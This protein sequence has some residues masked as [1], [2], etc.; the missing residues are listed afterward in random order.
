V[1]F[2]VLLMMALFS[3][4]TD[5]KEKSGDVTLFFVICAINLCVKDSR[6][7]CVAFVVCVKVVAICVVRCVRIFCVTFTWIFILL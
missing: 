5:D 7:S 6:G 2:V 4:H 1:R 3:D